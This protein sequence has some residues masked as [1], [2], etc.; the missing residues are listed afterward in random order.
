MPPTDQWPNG[1]AETV[2]DYGT[3]RARKISTRSCTEYFIDYQIPVAMLDATPDGGPKIDRSTPISMLFC[4]ANSLNNPFQKDCA[5]NREW[6]ADPNRAGPFGDYISFD[7]EEPFS[8][9]I[10][11]EVEAEAP[12][13]CDETYTLTA[14]IQDTLA[15]IDGEVRESVQEV[16]FWYYQDVNGDGVSNDGSAWTRIDGNAELVPGSLNK[17]RANWDSSSLPKGR[18]LIGVQALDDNTLV[19]DGMAPSGIDNRTFS[20]VTSNEMGQVY[21]DDD[22]ASG[23][24]SEG[25]P[26][27]FPGDFPEHDPD[28]SPGSDENWYGNPAVTGVQVAT[29]GVDLAVNACGVAPEIRKEVTPGNVAV[30]ETVSYTITIE[31]PANNADITVDSVTDVLPDGFT[32][33]STT[34]GTLSGFDAEPN[35][36]DGGTLAWQLSSP[37]TLSAGDSATLE[38]AASASDEAGTYNNI[39]RASTSFGMI[40][41]DPVPVNVD[42]ARLSLTKTPDAYLVTPDGATLLRYTLTW[43]ND[44]AVSLTDADIEDVLPSGVTYVDCGGGVSCEESGGTVAW[45]LGP[46]AGGA[47][48]SVT[49]DVTVDSDYASTSLVNTATLTAVAPDGTEVSRDSAVTIAV[50]VPLEAL[51][52]I[53]LQ[54]TADPIRVDPEGQ[55]AWTLSYRNYS[56]GS[57]TGVLLTDD[58]PAGFESITC[59]ATGSSHFGGCNVDGGTVTFHDG[60][61][62]GVSIPGDADGSVTVTGTAAGEPFVYPNPAINV[63]TITWPD[64]SESAQS[65]VGISG[66]TCDA[67][68]YFTADGGALGEPLDPDDAGTS[69]TTNG[70]AGNEIVFDSEPVTDPLELAERVLSMRLYVEASNN[71]SA[72]DISVTRID[73]S[74]NPDA[75]PLATFNQPIGNQS[76]WYAFSTEGAFDTGTDPILEGEGLRWT[77]Q[78]DHTNHDITIYYGGLVTNN[79]AEDV[80]ADSLTSIC[81]E[82]LAPNLTLS[83][84]VDKPGI[85]G[86]SE[87][88]TYTLTYA[89]T[90][91]STAEN[92]GLADT[93]PGDMDGCE[94]SSD[95]QNWSG[96]DTATEHV[97]QLGSVA[98]GATGIR[99]I[100]GESPEAPVSGTE[101]INTA[102]ISG[103]APVDTPVEDAA[104]TLVGPPGGEPVGSPELSITKSADKTAIGAGEEVAYTL[105]LINVGDGPAGPVAVSDTIPATDYFT[106]QSGSIAGGDSQTVNGDDLSWTIDSLAAGEGVE[107]SYRMGS[108]ATGIP[109]GITQLDNT[110]SASDN[111]YC[112]GEPLPE[113]CTSDTVTVSLSGNPVLG[114]TKSASPDTDLSPGDEV[115]WTLTVR[116]DGSTAANNVQ[117]ADDIVDGTHFVSIQEPGSFDAVNN[118][119]LLD[120]ENLGAGEQETLTFVSHVGTPSAGSHTLTNTATASASNAP[121]VSAE[122]AVVVTAAPQPG[123]VKSGPSSVPYPAARLVEGA[124]GATSLELESAALLEPGDYIQIGSDIRRVTARAG[125]VI[126]VD[127]PV[128]AGEGAEVTL[129]VGYALSYRND[130]DAAATGV[131]ITDSLPEGWRFAAADRNPDDT[132]ADTPA[133]GESGDVI[134]NID[135]LEPGDSGTLRVTAIPGTAGSAVNTVTLADDD[136]CSGEGVPDACSDD[137]VT[138]VGGLIVHKHTSTP[139]VQ[140]APYEP[141]D[142][143]AR[144]TIRLANSLTDS[145]DDVR[146]TDSLP[147]GFSYRPGTAEVDGVSQDPTFIDEDTDHTQPTWSSLTVPANGTLEITFQADVLENTGTATYDNEVEVEAPADVGVTPFDPLT[148]TDEDVTVIG[149]GSFVLEGYAFRDYGTLGAFDEPDQGVTAVRI[150][151]NDDPSLD[152]YEVYTDEFGYFR[153]VLPAA[154]WEVQLSENDANAE[155]LGGLTLFSGYSDPDIVELGDD[156]ASATSLFGFVDDGAESELSGTVFRDNGAGDGIADNGI[157]DGDEPGTNAAGLNVVVL[158]SA[159]TVLAVAP[160]GVEGGWSTSVSSE[161]GLTAY[162]TTESPD[163]GTTAAPDVLLPEGWDITGENDGVDDGQR[164]DIDATSNVTGLDFGIRLVGPDVY[165]R[166]AL[167]PETAPDGSTTAKLTFGNIG[168]STGEGITYQVNGLP[169]GL[170]GVECD[171]ATCRY[172]ADAGSA[173]ITGLPTALAPGQDLQALLH[174]TGPSD[175]TVEL[176]SLIATTTPDDPEPNNNNTASVVV[177][178]ESGAEVTTTIF[179]PDRVSEG[180]Q[181]GATAYFINIGSVPATGMSYALR[182]TPSEAVVTHEGQTCDVDEGTG[183]LDGCGLPDDLSTGEDV[184]VEVTYTAPAEGPVS[185]TSEVDAGNDTDETNNEATALTEIDSESMADVTTTVAPPATAGVADTAEVSVT[186]ANLG[187]LAADEVTYLLL[188]PPGLEDVGC[189]GAN[190][191][192]DSGSGRLTLDGLPETLHPGQQ[193]AFVVSYTAPEEGPVVVLSEIGT[194]TDEV[195]EDNNR[196]TALTEIVDGEAGLMQL[197]KTAY[198]GHDGG[199]SCPGTKE[200]VVVNKDRVSVDMTWC[201]I[202]TNT[203][204]TWLDDA[205]FTDA[206]LGVT[207]GN[208]DGMELA[209]GS[210]PLAPGETAVWYF[211]E[212]RDTSLEN[213]VSLEMTV[214]DEE[215]APV[216]EGEPVEAGDDTPAIF[217]YVFDPPFGVKTGEQQDGQDVVRWTMVWV[218]DNV[219]TAENVLITDPPPEGMTMLGALTCTAYGVTTVDVCTFDEPDGS[220]PR[221]RVRVRADIGPDFGVTL[222]TI[223]TAENRLEIAFDVLVDDPS[224]PDDYHNQGRAEWYPSGEDEPFEAETYDSTQLENLDPNTPPSERED[225]VPPAESTVP[226]DPVPP[227]NPRRIPTLMAWSLLLLSLLILILGMTARQRAGRH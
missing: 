171:G 160:T 143:V 148:T 12:G 92:V 62:N 113:S 71:A 56:S 209:S 201:F 34:G 4:T 58:L 173:V 97:F 132:A 67:A 38:F 36:G 41:S 116:N 208:Q 183:A 216:P 219:I 29:A 31:N 147:Q 2:W 70:N 102:T 63:G 83:K 103:D 47:S 190:C 212:T 81:T 50:D 198:L 115:T 114:L 64:G 197:V 117:I 74:G 110:A 23:E 203:G 80:F 211:E 100:R 184:P 73:E 51:P 25:N 213:F 5:L 77:I 158:D 193:T 52:A 156:V 22:W 104:T 146:V 10:I 87:T 7:Q 93:L 119:V 163:L 98:P 177:Q 168:A 76:A 54:K 214:V 66:Q 157:R 162:L 27:N 186:Y 16:T 222:G 131:S 144:Y 180:A 224:Q 153:Q 124:E 217:G 200:L 42:A 15:V 112:I 85:D 91:G 82:T 1:S 123:I 39:V 218:N 182:G 152:P 195:T 165:T 21:I 159:G 43:S 167:P 199:D 89:N 88:L 18:Y 107:L 6:A 226:F 196:A 126:T 207:P 108:A 149:E 178:G 55:V 122:A 35:S 127:D 111:E 138:T 26:I 223:D 49:L 166:I 46:L 78:G 86:A 192:Y 48:G 61:G 68:Y 44:S 120:L 191:S 79:D 174:F 90:G 105:T 172:D 187:P 65:A 84:T 151:V 176:T 141:D 20:Y 125:N 135:T 130:G 94:A 37:A 32:F 140:V 210:F 136:V 11:R 30:G 118:R 75:E 155:I 185:I 60:N 101:L 106:Y 227:G 28:M 154:T 202:A 40:E 205:V 128:T 109:A 215:G 72:I 133:V 96:C 59:D 33:G 145:V 188:L 137:A 170:D 150:E 204:D 8:Q 17:W 142:A 189:D 95:G 69:T 24:D 129:G 14:T 99:Y 225:E 169:T 161:T 194:T 57:A 179:A 19:D 45:Q 164:I 220:F 13:T 9:P 221:G 139:I 53:T 134:W 181:V 175:G 206:G 121:G 3:T